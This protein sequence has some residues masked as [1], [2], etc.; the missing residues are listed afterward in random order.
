MQRKQGRRSAE[1][2]E[3]TKLMI[4]SSAAFLFCEKGYNQVSVRDISERAGVAHS[5]IRHYFGSKV[6][7]W[8]EIIDQMHDYVDTYG[9]GLEASIGDD[10]E[11]KLG[12][13]RYLCH[14]MAYML[15]CP[16]LCQ[17]ML[18]YIHHP[19]NGA[20]DGEEYSP[21]IRS[22]VERGYAN[23]PDMIVRLSSN[24]NLTMWR[25]LTHAGG[26][27]AFK[28]FM[29]AAWPGKSYQQGLL[30][31]WKLYEQEVAREYDIS[32]DQRLTAS[33]IDELV[34]YVECQD[35]DLQKMYQQ[36]LELSKQASS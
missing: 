9:E 34:I 22:V 26:A 29:A 18:D 7:I 31:H 30:E 36:Q 16:Q 15:A 17:I 2:A 27:V 10:L 35:N 14:F 1:E 11:D 23:I 32:D 4:L 24:P 28:P 5:L 12:I 21:H 13:Y 6:Q 3:K 19:D 8:R 25:F 20:M 33:S